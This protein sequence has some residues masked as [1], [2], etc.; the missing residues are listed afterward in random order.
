MERRFLALVCIFLFGIGAILACSEVYAK[1]EDPRYGGSY[2]APL[3]NNPP[4]LD[5]AYVQDMYG[6]AVVHQLFE[7]LVRFGP[8]LYVIPALAKNWQVEDGGKTYRFFLR[9][10]AR[11][12]NGHPVTIKDVVFSITRLFKTDPQPTILPHLLKISGA[13]E[14]RNGKADKVSGLQ[15]V[16]DNTLAIHLEESYA[17]FLVAL[18]M[19]QAKIVPQD[20][21]EENEKAFGQEPI[22]NGAFRFVDWQQNKS[23]RLKSFD[24]YYGGKPFLDEIEFVIYPGINIEAVFHDFSKGKLEE[25]EVYGEFLQEL[26]KRKDLNWVHRPSLSLQFY[27]INCIHPRLDNPELRRALTMA[28]DRKKLMSSV[29]DNLD[30]PAN[31][32]LPPGLPGYNPLKQGAVVNAEAAEMHLKKAVG[33]LEIVSNSQSSYAQAELKFVRESW[34]SLGINVE[35][36]F[37]PDWSEF[38][39]YLE[40]QS[41]QLYRYVWFADLPDPDDFLRSLFSS[42]SQFNYMRYH[43][44]QVDQ[45]LQIAVAEIDPIKRASMYNDIQ[46]RILKSTPIIPISYL[47]INMVYQPYVNGIEVSALGAHTTLYDHVWLKKDSHE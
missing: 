7:G 42:D 45:M 36:K 44:K 39:Q 14:Y 1:E 25:M 24:K 2:R 23:I 28:I 43:D 31:Q 34:G 41:V 17:P 3:L 12:H 11:F 15:I 47:S 33:P 5:P 35:P 9:K 8:D 6:V 40:S 16:D 46:A 21:V 13:E 26:K 37:L 27:G 29:Y 38:E 20:V 22:G 10:D 32:I 4:T 18:G 30:E 19:Y